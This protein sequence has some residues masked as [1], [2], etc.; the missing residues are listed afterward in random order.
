MSPANISGEEHL[1][2][3]IFS[4]EFS[5]TIPIYQRPYGWT[6]DESSALLDDL[7]SFLGD[8][9]QSMD[10]LSPYFLG[11][12]VLIKR[13]SPSAEVVDGQQRLA[14]LTILLAVLRKLTAAKFADGLTHYL[15]QQG[16]LVEGTQN[17]YRLT[18]RDSDAEF[19]RDYVQDPDGLSTLEDQKLT[20]CTSVAT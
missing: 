20:S 2:S 9:K 3:K 10:E 18:L 15:Y 19:F 4:D 5:F 12:I 11:S 1:I 8:D 13:D 16:R 17:S 6:I 14:T 7:L